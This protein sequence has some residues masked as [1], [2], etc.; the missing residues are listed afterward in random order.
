MRGTFD[1]NKEQYPF[2]V[3]HV[4]T[5]DIAIR[6]QLT[7]EEIARQPLEGA[8]DSGER[9]AQAEHL[10]AEAVRLSQ[11][12]RKSNSAAFHAAEAAKS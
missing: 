5:N 9:K 11:E 12:S 1:F 8:Y 10:E 2:L 3:Q 6:H 4:G 7:G